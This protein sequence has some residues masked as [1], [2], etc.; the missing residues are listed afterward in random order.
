LF[1]T[2]R[3]F[4]YLKASRFAAEYPED[5]LP[6]RKN[7]SSR[8]TSPK[9]ERA[10]PSAWKNEKLYFRGDDYFRDLLKS[11]RGARK[12]VDFESYIFE[13]S[14]LG[15]LV[16]WELAR[17]VKRGV[18]VR[19]L[20]DGVGSPDFA[21]HYG[22]QLQKAGIPFKVYRSWPVFFS[23]AFKLLRL[24]HL[25]GSFGKVRAL[26][27]G[28][29]RR[30]HRK[31]GIVDDSQVWMGSFNIS[32]WHLEKVK[33]KDAWRDT[34][35]GLKGVTSPVFRAAF[36]I[37]WEDSWPH[38]RKRIYL[39]LMK[40]WVSLEVRESPI[41]LTL[42]RR[43]RLLFRRELLT[44]FKKAGSRV[45]IMTPYFIPNHALLKALADAARRGC[46]VRLILPFLSDVPMVRWVSMIFFPRLLRAGCRIFEYRDKVLHAKTLF[47]DDWVMVG[48][49]NLDY[50]SLRK[51]LEINVLPQDPKS[52]QVLERQYRRDLLDCQEITLADMGQRSWWQKFLSWLFYRFRFWF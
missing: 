51:D 23:S 4:E 14:R 22:P 37:A 49:S 2:G 6:T 41:R 47:V 21:S 8:K 42:T 7:H 27:N 13:P 24:K 12:S 48:S 15:N 33:G 44:R 3:A 43:L 46:D 26:F 30:D 1:S 20:V 9:K 25:N 28:G 10:V 39:Y 29:K 52:I 11:L 35:I 38:L 34:G 16:V 17:A 40:R 32:D 18:K 36:V 31:L 5:A 50:R 45:W 19:M